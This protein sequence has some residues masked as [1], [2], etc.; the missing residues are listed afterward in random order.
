MKGERAVKGEEPLLFLRLLE[1]PVSKEKRC[2]PWVE[3]VT[4]RGAHCARVCMMKREPGG[5]KLV[6]HQGADMG[7]R[8]HFL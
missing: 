4:S 3:P 6:A 2:S 1:P 7:G 5:E 8:S